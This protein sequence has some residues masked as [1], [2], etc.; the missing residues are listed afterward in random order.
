MS[1]TPHFKL[2]HSAFQIFYVLA[3]LFNLCIETRLDLRIGRLAHGIG[4]MDEGF[5]PLDLVIDLIDEIVVVHDCGNLEHKA[6]RP[7]KDMVKTRRASSPSFP[8]PL[9]GADIVSGL[10][11]RLSL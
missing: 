9:S 8:L 7:G 1:H 2:S 6:S 10:N 4:G 3:A 11:N 5:L